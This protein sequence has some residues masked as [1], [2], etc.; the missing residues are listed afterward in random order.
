MFSRYDS[1]VYPDNRYK[2]IDTPETDEIVIGGTAK[3]TF[4]LPFQWDGFI[5]SGRIY[6]K[7]GTKIVPILQGEVFYD[8]I[9]VRPEMLH[10]LPNGNTMIC[11]TLDPDYTKTFRKTVLDTYCQLEL[12]TK[13]DLSVYYCD[14]KKLRVLAPL[15]YKYTTADT[16]VS[17]GE[18]PMASEVTPGIMKLYQSG[19]QNVDGAVSQK[20]VTDSIGSIKLS[21][22]SEH[23]E[24][25][26]LKLPW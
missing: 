24:V 14:V 3:H 20:V 19:G 15:N 11:V 2:F 9:R 25:L 16:P 1:A 22:D 26:D 4:E 18:V 13:K 10:T 6:Y 8:Y 7:Q 21:M 23:P 12:I 17:P 5:S